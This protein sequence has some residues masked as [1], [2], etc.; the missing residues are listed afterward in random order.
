MIKKIVTVLL[1]SALSALFFSPFLMEKSLSF[2]FP[3]LTDLLYPRATV[4]Q[5]AGEHLLLVGVSSIFASGV[6]SLT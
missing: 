4:L 5:M 1:V 3:S 6:F 2:L